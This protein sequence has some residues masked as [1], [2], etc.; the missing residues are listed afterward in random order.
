MSNHMIY[1]GKIMLVLRLG[2][3]PLVNGVKI[4]EKST[5]YE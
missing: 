3:K 5:D 4:E 2:P 1:K